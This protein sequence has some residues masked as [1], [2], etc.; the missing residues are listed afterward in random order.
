MDNRVAQ[1]TF[2]HGASRRSALCTQLVRMALRRGTATGRYGYCRYSN[3]AFNPSDA[4][5]RLDDP[6]LRRV[7]E[8]LVE[9]WGLVQVTPIM[10]P[11]F[12][13]RI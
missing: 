3:T 9:Q 13:F 8:L 4:F 1:S 10:P 12:E 11:E 7:A 2:E 5:T 6:V